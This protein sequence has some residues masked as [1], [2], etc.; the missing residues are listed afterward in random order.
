L[1]GRFY[2]LSLLIISVILLSSCTGAVYPNPIPCGDTDS[3]IRAIEIANSDSD[4][5]TIELAAG[6]VYEL[7]EVYDLGGVGGSTGLP[8]ITSEITIIGHGASIMRALGGSYP[9]F[10]LILVGGDGDLFLRDLTL[11]NGYAYESPY[12]TDGERI[13]GGAIRNIGNLSLEGVTIL[14]NIASGAAGGIYNEGDMAIIHSTITRTHHQ[15]NAMPLSGGAAIHNKE[16]ASAIIVQTTI[17]DNGQPNPTDWA[18]STNYV[19]SNEYTSTMIIEN[20]T[21]SGNIGTAIGNHGDLDLIFSTIA[22]NEAGLHDTS[23]RVSS[24]DLIG[25]LFNNT[26]D[27][28]LNIDKITT[29]LNNMDSDWSCHVEHTIPPADIGLLPLAD[30]GGATRTHALDTASPAVDA[31]IGDCPVYEDQR[32]VTRPQNAICDIG[33]YEH[34]GIIPPVGGEIDIPPTETPVVPPVDDPGDD[35]GDKADRTPTPT[36]LPDR[37]DLFDIEKARLVMHDIPSGGTTLDLY[38]E[39]P[40]LLPGLEEEIPWDTRP[41]EYSAALGKALVSNCTYRGYSGRIYCTFELTEAYFG[42]AYPFMVMVNFCDIPVFSHPGVSIFDPDPPAPDP[43]NPITC[44]VNLNQS[45][46]TAAGGTYHQ[47]NQQCQCP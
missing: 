47:I 4:L 34:D 15:M 32:D 42:Y 16:G 6:C 28:Y 26:R 36:T 43:P 5:D 17:N 21:I 19:I 40:H 33:A 7:T 9:E 31:V 20:S 25:T 30:N 1:N 44:T 24:V 10:R 14:G 29:N 39:Y 46:C 11:Q 3:L 27:C 18:D 23:Q 13:S 12:P 35:P 8:Q 2:L 45:D 37:C 41:W 22:N 38:V